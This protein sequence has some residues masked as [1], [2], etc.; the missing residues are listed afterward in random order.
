MSPAVFGFF[1][2]DA[3][4]KLLSELPV[5]VIFSYEKKILEVARFFYLQIYG[6][7]FWAVALVMFFLSLWKSTEGEYPV[8]SR[9]LLIFYRS[10]KVILTVAF[11]PFLL[12]GLLISSIIIFTA[13]D[14]IPR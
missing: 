5:P 6:L 14:Q 4:Y 10:F 12:W 2:Q 1:Y 3:L 13:W 9:K 8:K 11:T 7:S